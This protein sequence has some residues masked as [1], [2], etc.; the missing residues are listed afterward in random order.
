MLLSDLIEDLNKVLKEKGDKEICVWVENPDG[1]LFLSK[2][3]KLDIVTINCE[4]YNLNTMNDEGYYL[5]H[6]RYSNEELPWGEF[7][8]INTKIDD[9]PLN[10]NVLKENID[11]KKL[12]HFIFLSPVLYNI[13]FPSVHD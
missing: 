1:E 6:Y 3:P 13:Y 4:K 11:Q 8:K 12:N 2:V 9:F 7:Y 10:Y 5:G